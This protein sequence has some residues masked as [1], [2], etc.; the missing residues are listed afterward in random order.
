[1]AESPV[2]LVTGGSRGIGAA[3]ARQMLARS[4]RV[5]VTGRDPEH[6]KRLAADLGDADGLLTLTGHAADWDAVRAHVDATVSRFGRLDT[7]VANAGFAVHDSLTENTRLQ[8]TGAGVGVT[9]VSPGATETGFFDAVGGL[10]ER[11][12]GYLPADQLAATIVGAITQPPG[13][14]VNTLT[15]RPIGSPR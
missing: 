3:V 4:H 5:A 9:L 11:P 10:P 12:G 2:T 13:V 6:L 7:A 1:M 8:V 14:D 15:V